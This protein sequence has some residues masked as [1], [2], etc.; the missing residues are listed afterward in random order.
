MYRDVAQTDN[1]AISPM[2]L[3]EIRGLADVTASLAWD[4]GI[5]RL[6]KTAE[7][8][9]MQSLLPHCEDKRKYNN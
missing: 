7:L 8:Q 1:I 2:F 4:E 5:V 6:P 9:A 3:R